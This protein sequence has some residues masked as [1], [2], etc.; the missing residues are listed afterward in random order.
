MDNVIRV[1]GTEYNDDRLRGMCVWEDKYREVEDE[2]I[3]L[4][5]EQ[6]I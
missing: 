3:K 5:E 2:M 4:E 1:P 6:V